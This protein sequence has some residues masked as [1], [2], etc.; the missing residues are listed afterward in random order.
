MVT[1]AMV[2][3]LGMQEACARGAL[4]GQVCYVTHDAFVH[5]FGSDVDPTQPQLL[6][7]QGSAFSVQVPPSPEIP[8]PTPTQPAC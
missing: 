5:I 4:D 2:E 7:H 8:P 3:D 6:A 1:I